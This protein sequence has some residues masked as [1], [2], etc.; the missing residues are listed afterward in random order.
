MIKQIRSLLSSITNRYTVRVVPVKWNTNGYRLRRKRTS[1]DDMG[2]MIHINKDI[3]PWS[4]VYETDKYDK[5]VATML[6][7]YIIQVKGKLYI[8]TPET[9]YSNDVLLDAYQSIVYGDI[10]SES[11]FFKDKHYF[12]K[13]VGKDIFLAVRKAI[14][15]VNEEYLIQIK[16]KRED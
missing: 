11:I 4:A 5:D 16:R 15:N 10:R 2:I 12:E 6:G 8:V 1:A 9:K 3:S 14:R 7:L 13:V